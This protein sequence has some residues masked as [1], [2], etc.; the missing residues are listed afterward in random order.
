MRLLQR[1]VHD[2]AVDAFDLDVHLQRGYALR[3]SGDFEIHIAQVVLVTEDVGQ[4]RETDAILNKPH[5][6]S[7]DRRL[8]LNAGVHEGKAGAT[9]RR[10]GTRP[11]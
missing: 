11:V 1:C 2:L 3:C 9:H 10:H 4:D 7:R 5:G 8:R 6:D